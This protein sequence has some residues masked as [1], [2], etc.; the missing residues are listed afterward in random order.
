MLDFLFVVSKSRNKRIEQMEKNRILIVEDN[1]FNLRLVSDLLEH[2]GFSVLQAVN[3]EEGIK[4]AHLENPVLILMDISLPGMDG[5]KATRLLKNDPGTKAIAIIALTAH[6]MDGD[7]EKALAAGCDDYITKP[8][9]TREF[10][11]KVTSFI[12]SREL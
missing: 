7:S 10:S 6:A 5:L 4:L 3:A 1:E 8:I 2:S 11:R 9:N 12:K